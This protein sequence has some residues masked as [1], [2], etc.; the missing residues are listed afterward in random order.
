MT[1]LAL[2]LAVATAQVS[3]TPAASAAPA[4]VWHNPVGTSYSIFD[5]CAGP[6]ELLNKI[7]PSPCVL[8]LGQA[9]VSVAYSNINTHGS[10]S[11]NGPQNGFDLPVS[12][13]ANIYPNLLIAFGVSKNAQFQINLPSDVNVATMRL[14]S[15]TATT[16]TSLYYKQLVYFNQK[17]FTLAAV[18]LGYI[19][20]TGTGSSPAYSVEL[21]LEQPLNANYSVGAYWTFKNAVTTTAIGS[22]QRGWSDPIG[23]YVTWSPTRGGFALFPM[24]EHEFS[25][26]RT[27]FIVDAS[28]LLSRRVEIN[29]EYGGLG[30]SGTST[31]PLANTF[32][33]AAD[34]YPRIFS[35]SLYYLVGAESNL[36]PQ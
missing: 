14:G 11:V 20:P 32:T 21:D 36:P 35:V 5:P 34:A 30:V 33:F 16:G 3:P 15:A 18:N 29:V 7:A 24:V 8:V 12:G 9:E 17:K 13:N 19:A 4:P 10:I 1:L 31:G 27:V 25:P 2:L 6:K 28:Q 22:T 23:V 26:N